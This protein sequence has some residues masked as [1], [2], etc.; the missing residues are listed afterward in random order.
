MA[1]TQAWIGSFFIFT[2]VMFP[3]LIKYSSSGGAYGKRFGFWGDKWSG[4]IIFDPEYSRLI[5]DMG[6]IA[7]GILSYL[8]ICLGINA[9]MWFYFDAVKY[10]I[11]Q[12]MPVPDDEV[13]WVPE[14]QDDGRHA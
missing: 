1:K 7:F 6:L 11:E 4:Q 9:V 10:S 14:E 12:P 13:P 8:L 5:I 2:M 3:P